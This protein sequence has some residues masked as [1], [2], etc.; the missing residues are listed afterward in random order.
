[1]AMQ[2]GPSLVDAQPQGP[3]RNI[4]VAPRGPPG[5]ARNLPVVDRE[6]VSIITDAFAL[7]I[8]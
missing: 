2:L 6:K 7:L 4:M 3:P 8:F 1:M 5:P